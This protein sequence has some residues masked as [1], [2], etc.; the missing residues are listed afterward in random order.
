MPVLDSGTQI[1]VYVRDLLVVILNASQ[2]FFGVE[3]MRLSVAHKIKKYT[4]LIL[5]AQH[6]ANSRDTVIGST[7]CPFQPRT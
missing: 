7:A 2:K 5:K 4:V 6:C 3:L 1:V